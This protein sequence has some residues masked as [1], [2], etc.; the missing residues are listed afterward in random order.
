M[1]KEK[2]EEK[3]KKEF[4][5]LVKVTA[6]PQGQFRISLKKSIVK[7]LQIKGADY[8]VFLKNE[9]GDIIIKKLKLKE[10]KS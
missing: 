6:A 4:V 5:D 3:G 9:D 10:E 1:K 2:K 8:L 7:E